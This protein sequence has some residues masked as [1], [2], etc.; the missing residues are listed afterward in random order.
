MQILKQHY[1]KTNQKKKVEIYFANPE[2]SKDKS[3]DQIKATG[4]IELG[5]INEDAKTKLII[6]YAKKYFLELK[7]NQIIHIGDAMGDS[8]GIYGIAQKGG[9]GIAFNYNKTL[10]EFL[11]EKIKKEELNIKMIDAKGKKSNLKHVLPHILKRKSY[12]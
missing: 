12:K 5:I 9:L 6:E 4:E 8:K 11:K 1:V 7:P 2:A 3:Y 10:E